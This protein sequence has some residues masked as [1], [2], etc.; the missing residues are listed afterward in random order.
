[1]VRCGLWK[2]PISEHD[3]EGSS[4]SSVD[5]SF[6]GLQGSPSLDVASLQ[7]EVDWPW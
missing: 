7:E 1:M 3:E 4:S 2:L 6:S 5:A